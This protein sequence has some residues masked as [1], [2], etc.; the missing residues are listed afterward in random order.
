[1]IVKNEFKKSFTCIIT[2]TQAQQNVIQTTSTNTSAS[3][4]G[5]LLVE[6]IGPA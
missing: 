2:R 5:Y 3:N 6:D 1:M 4:I